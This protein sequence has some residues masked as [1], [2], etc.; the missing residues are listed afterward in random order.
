LICHG[1]NIILL[2]YIKVN[3]A[4]EIPVNEMKIKFYTLGCRVNQFETAAM[5]AELR[6]RN[7]E[8]VDSG[9]DVVVVNTCAVTEESARKSRQAARRLMAQNPGAV[10]A[11]CGCWSQAEPEAA[12][13]LGAALVSGSGERKK[14]IERLDSLLKD[15]AGR[16]GAAAE[17]LTDEPGA[18]K[19]FERLPPA[20][21]RGRTRAYLKIQDGCANFCAYCVIP[22]LRGP[23]RSLPPEEAARQAALMAESGVREVTLTGIE[24]ASY[25]FGLAELVGKIG[26]A[27]PSVRLRLGSLEPRIISERFC[28]LLA[29]V[30]SFCPHFHLSLQS[31]C[32]ATLRRMGRGYDT[33]R[34]YRSVEL[35]R[36]YFDN[37][38]V[39][40]DLITGFPGETEEEFERTLSFMRS[41]D[42]SH[43][44]VFPYSERAG[45]RAALLPGQVPKAVRQLRAA[46]AIA[47]AAEMEKRFLLNQI[48]RTAEVLFEKREGRTPNNCPVL[49]PRQGLEGELLKVTIGGLDCRNGGKMSLTAII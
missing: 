23:S 24:L 28:E 10:L 49:P 35:V 42:F 46:A 13:A 45:T 15:G 1:G 30:E 16:A 36:R 43:V 22:Y 17:P 48:G 41:C 12:L 34:F 33:E 26:G 25:E 3:E 20:R 29:G 8:I 9:A 4:L 6:A 18:R 40:A 27:A 11:V 37:C 14:F 39:S 2:A 32:D 7:H 44:H 31:G 19:S 38:G 5:E 21:P 47:Q